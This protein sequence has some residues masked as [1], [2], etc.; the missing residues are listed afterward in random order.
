MSTT[1]TLDPA[2]LDAERAEAFAGRLLGVLAD[3]SL[4]VMCSIGHR[5]G[6]FDT[7]ARLAPST[8]AEIAEA[9]RLH[10]R[11]VREWLGAMTTGGVVEHHPASGRF[12]LPAEH[13]ASLTRAAGEDNL[14]RFL[15]FIPLLAQVQDPVADCFRNGGGVGYDHYPEFQQLM[16]E[17]SDETADAA[18]VDTILPL[19]DG[20]TGRLTDGAAV[21]DVGCGR[22]HALNVMARAFPASTFVGYDLDEQAIAKARHEARALGLDNVRFEVR[23]VTDLDGAGP[24]DLVTAF[25]AIH[26]QAHPARV[27]EEVADVLAP[28]GVFLMVDI[29]A[30]SELQDNVAIPWAPF[31]YTVSTLHCMTVSLAQGGEGLG[32]CWGEQTALQ[33]LHDAGFTSVRVA[34]L[35][36]DPFNNYYVAAVG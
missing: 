33:L 4:A 14:A 7:L 31:L 17:L 15:Q 27:L 29:R 21:A 23:D 5:V 26:D 9:A 28:D 35:E 12:H 22:G 16:A 30:S 32:T 36:D 13:A 24:F 1:S 18:L 6:L 3:A 25:D 19:A 8:P 34:E 11:Y 2:A 20:L 10:E